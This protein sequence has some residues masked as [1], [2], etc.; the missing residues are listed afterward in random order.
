MVEKGT[1]KTNSSHNLTLIRDLCNLHFFVGILLNQRRKGK[2]RGSTP[3]TLEGIYS[4]MK[5]KARAPAVWRGG[6]LFQQ[7]GC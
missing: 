2:I 7:E 4:P 5:Q 3:L 6:F 1:T